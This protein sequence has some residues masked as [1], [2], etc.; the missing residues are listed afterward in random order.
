MGAYIACGLTHVP[1]DQ[2][3]QYSE[4]IHRIASTLK[5]ASVDPVRYALMHSDPQLAER[6][7]RVSLQLVLAS[8][9]KSRSRMGSRYCFASGGRR[10]IEYRQHRIRIRT[11]ASTSSR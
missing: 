9:C 8:S 4:F 11:K 2:F 7:F 6:P 1:R 3:H 10:S 5:A